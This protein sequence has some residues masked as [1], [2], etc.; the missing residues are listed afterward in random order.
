MTREGGGWVG[1][2]QIQ[3]GCAVGEKL[4][5]LIHLKQFL[6]E[7]DVE[8]DKYEGRPVFISRKCTVKVLCCNIAIILILLIIM[9]IIIMYILFDIIDII[10]V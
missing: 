4:K 6:Q 8:E 9:I 5:Q 2:K 10:A 1:G 3:A 7:E